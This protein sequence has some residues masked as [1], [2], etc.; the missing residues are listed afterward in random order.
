[1]SLV[2]IVPWAGA[3]MGFIFLVETEE[4]K[5]WVLLWLGLMAIELQYQLRLTSARS[6]K[7][8]LRY[9]SLG[10]LSGLIFVAIALTSIIKTETGWGWTWRG[11]SLAIPR[12]RSPL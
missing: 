9:W 6:F 5:A 12:S 10:W 1:M 8:P 3:L 4:F 2:Y 7:Q 11:R